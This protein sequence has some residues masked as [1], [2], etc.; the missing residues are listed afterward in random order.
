VQQEQ[1]PVSPHQQQKLSKTTSALSKRPVR[2]CY[3]LAGFVVGGVLFL[4][5]NTLAGSLLT[6]VKSLE[7][8]LIVGASYLLAL[9]LYHSPEPKD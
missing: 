3:F 7:V 5:L 6:S 2:E 9:L 8:A 1:Q 4:A